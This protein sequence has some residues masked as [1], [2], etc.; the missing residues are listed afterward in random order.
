[1]TLPTRPSA[2]W[3]TPTRPTALGTPR[4]PRSINLPS[5]APANSRWPA[6]PTRPPT[7]PRAPW[8]STRPDVAALR[9]PF[10]STS[11]PT[12]R[13]SRP[14]ALIPL[15]APPWPNAS[16]FKA[17]VASRTSYPSSQRSC[18]LR[19]F[20]VCKSLLTRS[21]PALI[22]RVATANPPAL[23]TNVVAVSSSCSMWTRVQ[24]SFPGMHGRWTDPVGPTVWFHRESV[25]TTLGGHHSS[26]SRWTTME[27]KSST[28]M[29]SLFTTR[30]FR[31]A[32]SVSFLNMRPLF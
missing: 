16:R 8:P 32:K 4:S 11:S 14:S 12:P 10:A 22:A 30:P 21:H 23:P 2:A 24:V 1:M 13:L 26:L 5:P 28:A 20:P 6:H 9:L 17:V 29:M 7:A 19:C 27:V 25:G 31:D 15:E 3:P 18:F